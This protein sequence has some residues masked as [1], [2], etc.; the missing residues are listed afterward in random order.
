MARP[1]GTLAAAVGQATYRGPRWPGLPPAGGQASQAR[2]TARRMARFLLGPGLRG[3][4]ASVPPSSAVN[5]R[6]VLVPRGGHRLCLLLEAGTIPAS[7]GARGV[8]VLMGNVSWV[9]KYT[10]RGVVVHAVQGSEAEDEDSGPPG[11]F[12]ED[13][14]GDAEQRASGG[15]TDAGDPLGSTCSHGGLAELSACPSAAE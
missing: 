9:V 13:S 12:Q 14:P 11:Y 15:R 5:S 7:M 3:H 2:G 1:P 6:Q 4:A 8:A 10:T